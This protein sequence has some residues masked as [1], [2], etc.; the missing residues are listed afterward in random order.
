MKNTEKNPPTPPQEIDGP[1]ETAV[2][3]TTGYFRRTKNLGISLVLVTPLFVAYQIG[4]LT[5]DG[6]KNGADFLTGR[7]LDAAGRDEWR[8]ILFNFAILLI[9]AVSAFIS[10]R[11]GRPTGGTLLFV[12]CEATLYACIMGVA[13]SQLLIELGLEPPALSLSALD[14]VV[15]SL[16]AGVYEELV[17]RLLLLS[18]LFVLARR[19]KLR[20]S[21]ALVTAFVISSAVF[22][23]FHYVPLGH[24]AWELW[25]FSFRFAAGLVFA[26]IYSVRGFAV[27]VYTHAIYD[28]FVLVL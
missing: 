11:K 23:A 15:L 9:V 12:V 19:L 26:T 5:T 17:F 22:S 24:N 20:R 10:G 8:Y 2:E 3:T 18:G 7:I 13:I 16:G 6:W 4:L 21:V 28:I 27:A 14:N 1:E 25:S